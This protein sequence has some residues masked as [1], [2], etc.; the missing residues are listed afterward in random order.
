MNS[1]LAL[2]VEGERLLLHPERAVI[3]PRMRSLIVA[4][5]HFGK[6]SIFRRHGLA[7]A[8]GSEDEDRSRLTRLMRETA[9]E[10]LIIL[11]D[12]L[13]GT[14]T[15][16]GEEARSLDA[17]VRSMRPAAIEV[18]EGNHDRSAA[19]DVG[20]GILWHDSHRVEPPFRFIHDAEDADEREGWFTLSGHIHPVVRLEALQKVRARIPV[21][22]RRARGLVLPS[23]ARFTGGFVVKPAADE[24]LYAV[25][26]DR[27][28]AFAT[29]RAR[30]A[31]P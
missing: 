8:A 24:A 6:S 11:G 3:W 15:K 21:F 26:S 10:R 20:R 7:V 4:D 22:W 2:D 17:W 27:V 23:F 14:I 18:I 25:G 19:R 9:A 12:F 29:P 30:G 13:H 5:T 16:D 28:V 1:S 31:Q